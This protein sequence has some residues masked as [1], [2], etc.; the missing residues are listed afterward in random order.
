MVGTE[1]EKRPIYASLG[2]DPGLHELVPYLSLHVHNTVTAA[3]GSGR[4]A[5]EPSI[6]GGHEAL[7]L[8]GSQSSYAP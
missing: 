6:M 8:Y 5:L 7:S 3:V 4:G 2:G 1:V